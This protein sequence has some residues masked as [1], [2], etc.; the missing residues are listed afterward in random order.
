MRSFSRAGR[1]ELRLEQISMNRLINNVLRD[2][3]EVIKKKDINVKVEELPDALCDQKMIQHV[4]ANLISNAV[5]YSSEAERPKI[6][7]GFDEGLKSFYVK[8]NG[9][10]FD[11]QY[12]DK[13][14]QVFQRLQLPEE[15]D[16]TGIGLA[17]V[18][19]LV[20]RHHGKIWAESEKDSGS[21]FYVQLP[22]DGMGL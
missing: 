9:I 1:T 21:I 7:I 16:G 13:I 11:M 10:G 12:H 14:F 8:D 3:T 18:R 22:L 5:K 2:F 6:Q 17:I 20:E 19:R 4:Y 15:Y